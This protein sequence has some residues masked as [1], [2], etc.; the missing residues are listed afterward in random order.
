M[1]AA[2]AAVKAA[3]ELGADGKTMARA[4]VS[5]ALDAAAAGHS[6]DELR[7]A[8]TAIAVE[9]QQLQQQ[10]QQQQQEA[11][12]LRMRSLQR[13]GSIAAAG[14]YRSKVRGALRGGKRTAVESIQQECVQRVPSQ[15]PGTGVSTASSGDVWGLHTP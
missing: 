13:S 10:R 15:V 12:V 1:L 11:K 14:T 6:N 9:E 2:A 8:A 4:A 3:E 7:A 5:A